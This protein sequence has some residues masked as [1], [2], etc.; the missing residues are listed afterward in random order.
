[1]PGVIEDL[2][3]VDI[4]DIAIFRRPVLQVYL[5][6][7]LTG[8]DLALS[9]E[10]NEARRVLAAEFSAFADVR[11]DVY[12][13][14]EYTAPG[15][16]HTPEQVYCI[17]HKR[18]SE[19]DLVVFLAV[20]ASCGM[21]AECQIA[22]DATVPRIVIL[23]TG[24]D[25]SRMLIGSPARTIATITFS[26]GDDLRRRIRRSLPQISQ[27]VLAS[28]EPR[29][30]A[31]NTAAASGFN[32]FIVRRRI[33]CGMT[34]EQLA[35]RIGV[36]T[37]WLHHLERNPAATASVTICQAV[38]L[39]AELG[40]NMETPSDN[41]PLMF[42]VEDDGTLT[43]SAARSLDNLARF[44]ISLVDCDDATVL[45]IW[46]EYNTS[47]RMI[48]AEALAGRD[49]LDTSLSVREW[50]HLYQERQRRLF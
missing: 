34:T 5:A 46:Q 20:A 16:R 48:E 21:G 11:F 40:A 45:E 39:A 29:R 43:A 4:D 8:V 18:T 12:D 10:N 14:A 31:I 42:R 38:R 15:T 23:K 35:S 2:I 27:D 44:S 7:P 28:Y 49:P 41:S 25:A 32:Q 17:D 26:D 13:P 47:N 6:G 1:M 3:E 30:R 19:A 37:H 9:A 22:G 33:L 24:V 50:R 36:S